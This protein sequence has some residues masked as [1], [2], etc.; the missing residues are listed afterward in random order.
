MEPSMSNKFKAALAATSF[1]GAV[2]ATGAQ[3]DVNGFEI[4]IAQNQAVAAIVSEAVA[5]AKPVEPSII[6]ARTLDSNRESRDTN[7]QY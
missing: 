3:V 1:A 7:T 2:L 4:D 5:T 6:L